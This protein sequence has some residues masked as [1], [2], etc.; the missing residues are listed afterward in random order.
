MPRPLYPQGKSPRCPLDRR[1]GPTPLLSD[2]GE[3]KNSQSFKEYVLKWV[4][5][6]LSLCL[7]NHHVMKTYWGLEVYPHTFL[8]WVL[9]IG[10]LLYSRGKSPLVPTR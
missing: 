5:F 1:L 6:F 3:E 4:K 9:D 7:S 10:E 8:T 2:G